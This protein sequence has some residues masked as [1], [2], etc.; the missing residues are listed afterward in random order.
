MRLK[1]FTATALAL[2]LATAA[3]ASTIPLRAGDFG[4]A[5]LPCDNQP[6]A[7]IISF[8]GWN[9]AYPHATK[10]TDVV[11]N[12]SA[13]V[14]TIFETCRANGDGS[15]APPSTMRMKLRIVRADRFRLVDRQADYRRCGPVGWFDKH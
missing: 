11:R 14:L 5:S 8:D 3:T 15:A 13:G 12:R 2:F 1:S 6:N 4:D 9:F 10:C 7:G